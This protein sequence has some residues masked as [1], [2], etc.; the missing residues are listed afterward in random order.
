MKSS[1]CCWKNVQTSSRARAA[2]SCE[3]E[4]GDVSSATLCKM[5]DCC[6][7]LTGGIVS[8]PLGNGGGCIE[9]VTVIGEACIASSIAA[10]DG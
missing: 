4:T 7:E 1:C 6:M 3:G 9:L 10:R 2:S 8:A 5:V